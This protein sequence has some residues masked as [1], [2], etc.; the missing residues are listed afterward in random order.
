MIEEYV[1]MDRRHDDFYERLMEQRIQKLNNSEQPGMED[2]L[3]FPI[4]ALRAAPTTF[5]GNESVILASTLESTLLTFYHQHCVTP[6]ISQPYLVRSISRMNPPN[7]PITP[8]QQFIHK[9]RKSKNKNLN[10]FVPSPIILTHSQCFE[11]ALDKAI[12]LK[13][14]SFIWFLF[15]FLICFLFLGTRQLPMMFSVFLFNSR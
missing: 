7:G 11:L 14:S 6:D 5:L 2:S 9:S 1:P 13:T 8:I 4:E 3:P 15:P 12:N 10:T